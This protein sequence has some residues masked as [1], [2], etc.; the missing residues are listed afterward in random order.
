M[1]IIIIIKICCVGTVENEPGQKQR[2]TA[3]E[4]QRKRKEEKKR[5]MFFQDSISFHHNKP[6][7]SSLLFF[8][9]IY[10]FV[11]SSLLL[12]SKNTILL[13]FSYI[14]VG[15]VVRRVR[16]VYILSCPHVYDLNEHTIYADVFWLHK[17]IY[18]YTNIY[19]IVYLN[20]RVL[21]YIF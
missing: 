11:G 4:R 21:Y 1:F 13:H 2:I 6:F 20:I 3:K 15:W 9:H 18:E 5:Q 17:N 19:S 7:A 14:I 16:R 8:L 12:Y 10:S